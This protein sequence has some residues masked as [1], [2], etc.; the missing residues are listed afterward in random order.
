MI[1]FA[2]PS[3]DTIPIVIGIK[4]QDYQKKLLS[5]RDF[6]IGIV[7]IAVPKETNAF[8]KR[9]ALTPDVVQM[10]IKA[11]FE[12]AV[13]KDAGLNSYFEDSIYENTGAKIIADKNPLYSTADVILKINP[14]SVEDINLMKK[15]SVLISLIY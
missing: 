9:V 5:L 7:L 3:Q 13:E 11:G 2:V 4:T 12:V 10:V 8:E 15:D 6:K 14:P 1:K